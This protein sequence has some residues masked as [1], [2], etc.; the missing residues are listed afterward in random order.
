MILCRGSAILVYVRGGNG[1]M[2]LEVVARRETRRDALDASS[3]RAS[4]DLPFRWRCGC[5][6]FTAT[7]IPVPGVQLLWLVNPVPCSGYLDLPSNLDCLTSMFST[8]EADIRPGS[9]LGMFEL[10]TLRN[11]L[12]EGPVPEEPLNRVFIVEC[13]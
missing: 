10:G 3:T 4:L 9:G 11:G 1:R 13:A 6:T 7:V 8:L 5:T 2:Q 12:K